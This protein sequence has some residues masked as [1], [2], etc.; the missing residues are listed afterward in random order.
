MRV[1]GNSEQN[2]MKTID[3]SS[4]NPSMYGNDRNQLVGGVDGEVHSLSVRSTGGSGAVDAGA[5]LGPQ[6]NEKRRLTLEDVERRF[7][8]SAAILGAY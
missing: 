1:V 5:A 6:K 4:L 2:G 3:S 7:R 8:R